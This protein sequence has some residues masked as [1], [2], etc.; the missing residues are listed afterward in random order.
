MQEERAARRKT[1]ASATESL[2]V[3]TSDLATTLTG[4]R[5]KWLIAN[6]LMRSV[7]LDHILE[8]P[9]RCQV[10]IQ[11]PATLDKLAANA[12]IQP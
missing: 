10:A 11:N 2:P 7:I 12:L 8:M 5:R 1:L 4:K 9:N 6:A 3:L